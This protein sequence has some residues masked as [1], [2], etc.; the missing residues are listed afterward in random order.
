MARRGKAERSRRRRDLVAAR[1]AQ[2][3]PWLRKKLDLEGAP[4]TIVRFVAWGT[5][6]ADRE[7]RMK[8]ALLLRRPSAFG[9][10]RWPREP[11]A[12]SAWA[13]LHREW[14]QLAPDEIAP[15]VYEAVIAAHAAKSGRGLQPT[16]EVTAILAQLAALAE[17]RDALLAKVRSVA[18][19]A[20]SVDLP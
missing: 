19:V 15:A 6:P 4:T 20:P 11:E 9:G 3:H 2:L 14:P 13:L 16:P 1:I 7:A 8:L 18:R 17:E 10:L 5:S 12:A